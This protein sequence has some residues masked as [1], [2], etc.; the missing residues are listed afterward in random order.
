MKVRFQ[1]LKPG[2]EVVNPHGPGGKIIGCGRRF[3]QGFG[4]GDD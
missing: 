4:I 3:E 1:G 2:I